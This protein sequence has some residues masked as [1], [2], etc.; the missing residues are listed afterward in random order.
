MAFPPGHVNSLQL[1]IVPTTMPNT[2]P[3]CLRPWGLGILLVAHILRSRSYSRLY[4]G[5]WLSDCRFEVGWAGDL[6]IVAYLRS[7]QIGGRKVG[8]EVGHLRW[9]FAR[10]RQREGKWRGEGK[11]LGWSCEVE[12]L[13]AWGELSIDFSRSTILGGSQG[14]F[15]GSN[16]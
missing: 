8:L 3:Q 13:P 9:A 11:G 10:P 16:G 5:W 6:W 14:R 4:G 15:I 12:G 7:L 1:G 2:L